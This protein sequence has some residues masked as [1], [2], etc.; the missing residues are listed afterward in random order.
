M[1]RDFRLLRFLTPWSTGSMTSWNTGNSATSMR[2]RI[3][4]SC[5]SAS[6]S[7]GTTIKSWT[8]STLAI[9]TTSTRLSHA[10]ENGS[11]QPCRMLSF[12]SGFPYFLA[13]VYRNIQAIN[14]TY[15]LTSLPFLTLQPYVT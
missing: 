1:Q 4:A 15:I 9:I 14:P 7:S 10:L 12:M 11:S 13:K 2:K 5:R 3:L 6:S 8:A